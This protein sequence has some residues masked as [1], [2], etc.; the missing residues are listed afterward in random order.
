[1]AFS[2]R[3]LRWVIAAAVLVLVVV[4]FGYIVM[5]RFKALLVY[6]NLLSKT[7]TK[8]SHDSTGVTFTQ[9]LK[10]HTVITIHSSKATQVGDQQWRLHDVTMTVNNPKDG[11]TDRITGSE[12]TYDQKEGVV[13]A[14]GEV[15]IDLEAPQSLTSGGRGANEAKHASRYAPRATEGAEPANVIHVRT[16]GLVYMRKLGLAATDQPVEFRYGGIVCTS[17]GAEFN[18]SQSTLHLLAKVVADGVMHN[19]PIH[20]TANTADVDRSA[21]LATL[22]HT[23]A[24]SQGRTGSADLTVLTLRSDGSVESAKATGNVAMTSKTQ[25]LT[26]AELTA[27]VGKDNLP[28]SARLK[29]GVQLVDTN[30]LRPLHGAAAQ[31]DLGF[32]S[33]GNLKKVTATGSPL[34]TM[35]DKRAA[36]AMDGR[37]LQREMHGDTIVAGFRTAAKGKNTHGTTQIT[38]LHATGAAET[39]GESLAGAKTGKTATP[40]MKLT[41]LTADDIDLGFM[42]GAD[43][44]AEPQKLAAVGHTLLRQDAPAGERETSAGDRLDAQFA[45]SVVQGKTQLALAN[46]VQTGHVVV[47]RSSAVK[48]A[49]AGRGSVQTRE[50][51]DGEKRGIDIAG[52]KAGGAGQ[53]FGSATAE[54]ASYDG[55]SEKLTLT[56][57]P[58]LTQDNA[59]LTAATVVLDDK[60]QDADATG[61]VQATLAGA[62]AGSA[63]AS[64]GKVAPYT[65][66]LAA[67]AHLTHAT[68]QAEFHGTDALPAKMWQEASQVQAA[69]LL[70]DDVKHTFSARG[71]GP[72]SVVHSVFV[73]G[74]TASGGAT[75]LNGSAKKSG[76]TNFA[77][78]TSA[79]LDYSDVSRQAVFTGAPG[80]VIESD[81]G[82][83]RAQKATAYLLPGAAG[84]SGT[85][86]GGSLDRIVIAGDVQLDQPGRHG[87]GEQLVYTAATGESLLTGAPGRLPKVE[88]AQ[89]GSIT[90]ASLLV[91]DAG[92]TIIVSGEDAV[93]KGHVHTETHVDAKGQG[94]ERAAKERQ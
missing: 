21:N 91:G 66:V 24:E 17:Q 76:R 81:S 58:R 30:P 94:K 60:T 23:A 90:G 86:V 52:G 3:R 31:A 29:G 56:G 93:T 85:P 36:V 70:L 55:A 13:R 77:K 54:R 49:E 83:I 38:D 80:V 8:I 65:H 1:M 87:T 35:E 34:M 4:V 27:T 32:D 72:G 19:Q 40:Q 41:T 73:G 44:K 57:G 10:D 67:S 51:R 16:S 2:I 92:S 22:M 14:I 5:G 62:N 37:G 61:N 6:K 47:H 45:Q 74:G 26:A 48:M 59:T 79:R 9:S 84:S 50:N 25:R 88:D 68:G 33:A 89:Q 82:V 15:H 78:V 75:P 11:R 71:A 28:E 42:N 39:H 7:G 53:Q 64:A 20:I 46:A 63:G 18:T 43:G 12:F 69:N